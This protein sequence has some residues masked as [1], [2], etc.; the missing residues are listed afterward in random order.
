LKYVVKTHKNNEIDIQL[1]ENNKVP[2]HVHVYCNNI[3][4]NSFE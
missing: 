4:F 2:W 3:K 1:L